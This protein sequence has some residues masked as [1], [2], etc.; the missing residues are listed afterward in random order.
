MHP[1]VFHC[2]LG[3]TEN[4]SNFIHLEP[5]EETKVDNFCLTLVEAGELF[6]SPVQAPRSS[7][8]EPRAWSIRRRLMM[9]APT[10]TKCV[11]PR[12]FTRDWSTSFR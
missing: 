9:L 11:R 2:A 7:R 5:R 12:Q 10:A 1:V 3:H 4:M 8:P 6:D